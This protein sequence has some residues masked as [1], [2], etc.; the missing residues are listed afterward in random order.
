MSRQTGAGRLRERVHFQSR[1]VVDDGYGNTRGAWVTRF[2]VAAG[3][4][5]LRGGE[6]VMASR[7]QGVQP[8]V[9]TV[10]QSSQT[11]E[12]A[13]DWRV[14]DARDASRVFAITAPPTD[15]DALGLWLDILVTQGEPG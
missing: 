10:R 6:Q 2:T 3:L 9:L 14:V 13:S 8:Y 12:V 4:R 11:R 7:L 5:P 15:P 1:T